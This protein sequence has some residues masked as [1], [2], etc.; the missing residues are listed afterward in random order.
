MK[1]LLRVA[2]LL[3]ASGL[4]FSAP[5]NAVVATVTVTVTGSVAATAITCTPVTSFTAGS[6]PAG[7]IVCPI[8]VTPSGWTGVLTLSG[9]NAASF[10]IAGTNLVVGSTALPNGTYNVSITPAP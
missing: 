5:A 1:I 3:F 10:A 4:M 8:V 7:A 2:A 6:A 9:T